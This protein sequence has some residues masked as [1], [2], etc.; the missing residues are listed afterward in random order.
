MQ[1]SDR[2]K[3]HNRGD[4][5]FFCEGL[6]K[7]EGFKFSAP[8][9]KS[10]GWGVGAHLFPCISI[11]RLK[12][13]EEHHLVEAGAAYSKATPLCSRG[14]FLQESGEN[15]HS[16]PLPRRLVKQLAHTMSTERVLQRISSRGKQD[17]ASFLLLFFLYH[18]FIYFLI[19]STPYFYFLI[20]FA[21][22]IYIIY[23]LLFI[24]TT[25]S[26]IYSWLYYI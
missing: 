25:Y 24:F 26:I 16:K 1:D 19:F 9:V 4:W 21:F 17:I 8:V 23:F 6:L 14:T 12:G 10:G 18:F 15:Q 13:A 11:V 2:N 3:G 5:L 20:N 7:S 22:F